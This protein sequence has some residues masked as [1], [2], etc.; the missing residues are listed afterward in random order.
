[1]NHSPRRSAGQLPSDAAKNAGFTL[2]EALVAMA[3][4][5]I[6][7]AV[8]TPSWLG[9]WE[10]RQVT[11][12][13]QMMYQA[14][15]STQ[16][17]AMQYREDRRFSLRQTGNHLEW[18]SHPESVSAVQVPHWQA[19]PFQVILAD[20]DNTLL[21]KN[22]IYYVRFNFQGDVDS[23]LGTVTVTGANGGEYNAA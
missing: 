18:V 1:M 11:A 12:V 7:A 3:V 13:Q 16:R 14:M 9:F 5:G 6:V 21:K 23:R 15:R 8:A 2:F 19:L 17:D 4:I 20:Q 10:R 22:D